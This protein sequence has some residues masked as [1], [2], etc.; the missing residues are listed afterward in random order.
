MNDLHFLGS[1]NCLRALVHVAYL[2]AA[3]MWA[4]DA[5]APKRKDAG[6][7]LVPLI[8]IDGV[9]LSDAIRN[10][11]GHIDMNYILDPSTPGSGVGAGKQAQ[12]PL[13]SRRWE[14]VY[15]LDALRDVLNQHRLMLVTN[16]AT[17]VARIAPTGLGV[18]PAPMTLPSS[19]DNRPVPL[20]K[21]DDMTLG[22]S[23]RHV[24]RLAGLRVWFDP[25]VP[26]SLLD[27]NIRVRWT[28]LT[29]RQA[30]AALSDN[31]GLVLVENPVTR[32]ARVRLKE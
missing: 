32:G 12:E 26:V 11:A 16:P 17:T 2:S 9:P 25:E 21:L 22:E 18:K 30:L 20:L 24:G 1:L 29:G 4:A 27:E 14:D 31:Y 5:D 6:P 8:V 15:V 28:R 19:A 7:E 23:L 13:V 10:M 3:M